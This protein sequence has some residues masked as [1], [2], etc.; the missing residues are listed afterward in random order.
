M[1]FR[2]MP[3]VEARKTEMSKENLAHFDC[4]LMIKIWCIG[5]SKGLPWHFGLGFGNK[6]RDPLF[7]DLKVLV[8]ATW[9]AFMAEAFTSCATPFASTCW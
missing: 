1:G 5:G 4:R 7:K 8:R 9:R 2:G 6:E 3:R